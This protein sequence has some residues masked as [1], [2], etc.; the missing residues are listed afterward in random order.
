[1]GTA[2]DRLHSPVAGWIA[3]IQ[4]TPPPVHGVQARLITNQMAFDPVCFSDSFKVS[5]HFSNLLSEIQSENRS[6]KIR[7]NQ[8]LRC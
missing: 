2:P 3:F 8:G 1:M 5:C 4:T 7:F 6:G